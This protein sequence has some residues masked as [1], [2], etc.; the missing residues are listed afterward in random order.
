[1]C[2]NQILSHCL[3]S[4][5]SDILAFE[6]IPSYSKTCIITHW[7]E[8]LKSKSYSKMYTLKAHPAWW[9]KGFSP[10][11]VLVVGGHQKHDVPQG[12]VRMQQLTFDVLVIP[13]ATK[14]NHKRSSTQ[15]CFAQ[16]YGPSSDKQETS[17]FRSRRWSLPCTHLSLTYNS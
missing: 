13:R 9:N 14:L 5:H 10:A 1:M 17:S 6:N 12:V 8:G 16:R 15:L 11:Q 3:T 2:C 4:L 7:L